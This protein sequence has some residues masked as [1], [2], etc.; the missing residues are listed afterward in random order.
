MFGKPG[1]HEQCLPPNQL[2]ATIVL[3][4]NTETYGLGAKFIKKKK[5]KNGVKKTGEKRGKE[6]DVGFKRGRLGEFRH[7]NRI[8]LIS[9]KPNYT[10]ILK[11]PRILMF[12]ETNFKGLGNSHLT[13]SQQ[14]RL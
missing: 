13:N 2:N 11:L 9:A 5:R 1:W 10:T 12:K 3:W 6:R 7:L 8:I 4:E 14:N